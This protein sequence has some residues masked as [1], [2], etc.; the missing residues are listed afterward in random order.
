MKKGWV[1]RFRKQLQDNFRLA[2]LTLFGVISFFFLGPFAVYR[3]LIGDYLEAVIEFAVLFAVAANVVWAWRRDDPLVPT[4][5]VAVIVTIAATSIILLLGDVSIYWAYVALIINLVL[6]HRHVG[7]LL[8]LALVG[9]IAIHG[10]AFASTVH[11][12]AFIATAVLVSVYA[13][14]FATQ[15]EQQRQRLQTQAERD[16][17][18]G[19][20]NRRLLESSLPEIAGQGKTGALPHSVALLDLDRFKRVNDEFGHAA[21]DRV[22]QDLAGILEQS[23]RGQD[24]LFRIGG[25]EFVLLMPET[26]I[27]GAQVVAE[28]IRQRTQS[29]L[30]SPGGSVTVSIGIAEI[31]PADTDWDHWLEK[32]DRAL[33]EAKRSG[34]NRI[35]AWKPRNPGKQ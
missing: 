16:P 1:Q 22:L 9:I 14:I 28:K 31:D 24:R 8:N 33:Y 32:A 15:T 27:E 30:S 13:F 3:A 11:L 35:Q 34:R 29:R 26:T 23:T 19:V 17:L 18:T 7:L 6:T 25:E 20:G 2:S 5:I 21:G 10:G 12:S 4:T